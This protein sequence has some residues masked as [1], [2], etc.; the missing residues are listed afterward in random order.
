VSQEDYASRSVLF[1][2]HPPMEERQQV[3]AE[4]A[5]ELARPEATKVAAEAYRAALS[6]FRNQL[7]ED[8]LRR[9]RYG[10]TLVLLARMQKTLPADGEIEFYRGEV[11]RMR[12]GKDDLELALQS[13]RQA[14]AMPGVPPE[15]FRSE[16]FVLRQMKQDSESRRAFRR[17]LDLKPA[18]DDAEL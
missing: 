17:Y 1:A 16:G 10:E 5:K 11:Y 12:N 4:A 9:R 15:V 18:A 6:P 14:Q 7:L 2:S 8:E 13:Y 3:L